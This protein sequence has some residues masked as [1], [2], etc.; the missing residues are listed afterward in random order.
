MSVSP[1]DSGGGGFYVEIEIK[2]RHERQNWLINEN[3]NR[4]QR[5]YALRKGADRLIEWC[6]KISQFSISRH[7]CDTFF[8]IN[9]WLSNY[10]RFCDY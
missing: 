3:V 9:K 4:S 7:E 2:Q 8:V 10:I 6:S 5:N 1:I